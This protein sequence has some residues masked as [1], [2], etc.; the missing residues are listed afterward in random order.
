ME[1]VL[2][3]IKVKIISDKEWGKLK[4]GKAKGVSNAFDVKICNWNSANKRDFLKSL[5]S[6]G[7][8]ILSTVASATEDPY[9]YAAIRQQIDV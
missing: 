1:R 8:I 6:F 7:E 4:V 5:S 9:V 2:I 3:D